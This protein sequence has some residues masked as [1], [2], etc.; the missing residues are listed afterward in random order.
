MSAGSKE[1][2]AI[3]FLR[4]FLRAF[5]T[6]PPFS[7]VHATDYYMPVNQRGMKLGAPIGIE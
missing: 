2:C 7:T 6:S 5:T 1:T 3:G 4:F